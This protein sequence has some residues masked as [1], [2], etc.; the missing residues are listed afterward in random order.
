MLGVLLLFGMCGAAL[1]IALTL[2]FS[3]LR[4]YRRTGGRAF[5]LA[6]IGFALLGFETVV[7][8]ASFFNIYL[9][10]IGVEHLEAAFN[11][12]GLGLLLLSIK[13]QT[14]SPSAR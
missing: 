1:L 2:S 11:V 8:L 5:Q 14:E 4:A 3:G 10:P 12:A 9:H 7:D 6:A 13:Y